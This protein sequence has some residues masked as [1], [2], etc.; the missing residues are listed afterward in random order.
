MTLSVGRRL[1]RPRKAAV[2]TPIG[3]CVCSV[4]PLG[5]RI[6]GPD[7]VGAHHGPDPAPAHA[8]GV[9]PWAPGERGHGVRIIPHFVT[10]RHIESGELPPTVDPLAY[11]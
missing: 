1:I 7:N 4:S 10:G 8:A 2:R 3:V 9:Q 5:H 11:L 6:E